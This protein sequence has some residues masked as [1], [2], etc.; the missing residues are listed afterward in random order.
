MISFNEIVSGLIFD[1]IKDEI[2]FAEKDKG[3]FL[4]NHRIKVSKKKDIDE[5]LFAIGESLKIEHDFLSRKSG[6]AALDLAY[7]AAG[8]YDG[9]FQKKL[10]LWDIASGILLVQEAGG[11]ISDININNFKNLNIIASNSNINRD[12]KKKLPKF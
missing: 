4:N 7:V 9:Y 10:N 3:A 2:F 8:R 1:P 12:F 5:C 11:I 6:C